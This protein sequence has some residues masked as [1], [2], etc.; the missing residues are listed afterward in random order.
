MAHS[1]DFKGTEINS[2]RMLWSMAGNIAMVHRVF[3]GMTFGVNG[4][5]FCPVIPRSY[6]GIKTLSGFKYRHATLNIKVIGFGK[7]IRS[8]KI[9]GNKMTNAYVE[10]TVTGTINIEIEMDN[11]AFDQQAFHLTQNHFTLPNPVLVRNDNEISWL[12]IPN[13]V[14]YKI[15]RN[16]QEWART[17]NNNV[18]INTAEPA[19]F[20]VSAIDAE[21]Y[22]SFISEPLLIATEGSINTFQMERFAQ[23]SNRMYS[24]H[25]ADG[26]IEISNDL[27]QTIPLEVSVD[28]DGK[29]LVDFRY[30]NGSGPWNTDNKCAIRSLYLD[31]NYIGSFVFPQRGQEEWSDWGFSNALVLNLK[32]GNNQLHLKF[33]LWNNNMNVGIN[34][35]MLDYVRFI[36]VE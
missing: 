34:R 7:N 11:I 25:T 29:Y 31:D 9:N 1:G 10:S 26:F 32:K 12:P 24:G 8:F 36:R 4:I 13:A 28:D 17:E 6:D 23:K 16:G 33:E 14:Q 35:A 15:Y 18:K 22:E 2:D 30:S 21:G 19:E 3:M 5:K 27:N 20:S